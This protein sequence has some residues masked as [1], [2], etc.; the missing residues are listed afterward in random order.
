MKQ[1]HLDLDLKNCTLDFYRHIGSLKPKITAIFARSKKTQMKPLK[2]LLL[3]FFGISKP[4]MD[5]K[6]TTNL[7]K[8][9]MFQNTNN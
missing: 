2:R 3:L 5:E 7:L 6:T 9:K 8:M 4:L 1:Q